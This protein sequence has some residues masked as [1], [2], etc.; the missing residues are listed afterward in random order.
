MIP[1]ALHSVAY[2]F[3][4]AGLCAE[5]KQSVSELLLSVQIFSNLKHPK[6][7][8]YKTHQVIQKHTKKPP[9]L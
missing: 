2:A 3:R 5:S 7:Q 9:V 1:S 4:D 6:S 8:C